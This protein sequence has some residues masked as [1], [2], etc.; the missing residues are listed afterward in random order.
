MNI[1]DIAVIMS[2]NSKRVRM[3]NKKRVLKRVKQEA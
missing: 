1:I 3:M 2:Q